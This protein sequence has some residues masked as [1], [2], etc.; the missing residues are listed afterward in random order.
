[1]CPFSLSPCRPRIQADDL[2]PTEYDCRPAAKEVASNEEYRGSKANGS[3]VDEIQA[4]RSPRFSP[5]LWPVQF[6]ALPALLGMM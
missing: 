3:K 5:P 1:M 4:V 6:T 2:R